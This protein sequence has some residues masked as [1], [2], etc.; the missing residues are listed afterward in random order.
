MTMRNEGRLSIIVSLT[1][2]IAAIFIWLGVLY[3]I[4]HFAAKYW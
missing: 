2:G 1:A 4:I 3:V